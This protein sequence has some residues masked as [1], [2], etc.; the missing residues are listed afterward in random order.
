MQE[1]ISKNRAIRKEYRWFYQI[2]VIAVVLLLGI[3]LG[4]IHFRT[5]Q[6]AP[7]RE[8]FEMNLLTEGLG[9]LVSTAITVLIV[10]RL[11]ENRET[12]RLK[13][14]LVREVGSGSKEFA[15]NAVSWLRAEGWLTGGDGLLRGENLQDANLE[16]ALLQEANLAGAN[17]QDASLVRTKLQGARL[18]GANLTNTNLQD[19]SL[20]GTNLQGA[21]LENIE[22]QGADL[23]GADLRGANLVEAKLEKANLFGAILPDGTICNTHYPDMEKFTNKSHDD[24]EKTRARIEAL[25]LP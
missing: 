7:A 19:A 12:E 9:V 6:S 24:F 3:W 21:R 10:D 20:I 8:G 23:F 25:A 11:A 14:R 22:L 17:L 15:A 4:T 5:T 16:G 2:L 1:R 18:E 13:R